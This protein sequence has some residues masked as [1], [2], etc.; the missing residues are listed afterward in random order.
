MNKIAPII[1][2]DAKIKRCYTCACW[3]GDKKKVL[4]QM[5]ADPQCMD[6]F[7]GWPESGDCGISY[8]WSALT[9]TGDA[10]ATLEVDANFGCPY[11]VGE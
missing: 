8:E 4:E 9:I 5:E 6:L 2:S 11:W 7:K 10:T 3:Q 1:A